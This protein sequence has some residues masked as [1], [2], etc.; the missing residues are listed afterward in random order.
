MPHVRATEYKQP[1][2]KSF[3]LKYV[4]VIHR[5]HK[6]TPYQ[7]NTF[8]QEDRGWDCSDTHPFVFM[9]GNTQ[10]LQQPVKGFVCAWFQFKVELLS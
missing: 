8:P 2:T 3:Q 7:A 10:Q 5:H 1:D 6:R 9:N 4:E